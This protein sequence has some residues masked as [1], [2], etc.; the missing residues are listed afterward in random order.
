VYETV[1]QRLRNW[2]EVDGAKQVVD[3]RDKVR[4]SERNNQLIITTMKQVD[5]LE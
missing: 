4:H 5:E 1:S 3:S 2:N